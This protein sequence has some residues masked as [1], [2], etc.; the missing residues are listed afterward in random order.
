[1][2]LKKIP[3]AG[4][5]KH[6]KGKL[7]AYVIEVEG[8][9]REIPPEKVSVCAGDPYTIAEISFDYDEE[10]NSCIEPIAIG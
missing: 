3:K 7:I 10:T 4:S 6:L 5:I 8:E 1:M 9:R 2:T